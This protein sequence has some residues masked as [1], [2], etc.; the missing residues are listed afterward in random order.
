M[1]TQTHSHVQL[2]TPDSTYRCVQGAAAHGPQ[3]RHPLAQN[4]GQLTGI[5]QPQPLRGA[6]AGLGSCPND[7]QHSHVSGVQ[8]FSHTRICCNDPSCANMAPRDT[9]ASAMSGSRQVSQRTCAGSCCARER[10]LMCAF[11]TSRC[12]ACWE[13]SWTVGSIHLKPLRRKLVPSFLPHSD[14]V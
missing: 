10:R 3:G 7:S 8:A 12:E 14:N 2:Y 5:R 11:H 1:L 9:H 13:V 6:R 4:V